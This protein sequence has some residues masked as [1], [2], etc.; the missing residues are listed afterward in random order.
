MKFFEFLED[1]NGK[2]SGLRIAILVWIVTICFN[3]IYLSIVKQVFVGP[4]TS[5]ITGLGMLLG[6][7]V[8]QNF[9]EN[10]ASEILVKTDSKT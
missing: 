9:T 1:P 2:L 4:D 7:K 3:S 8:A 5:M 6:S 10:K